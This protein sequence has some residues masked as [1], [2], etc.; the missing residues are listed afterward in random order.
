MKKKEQ[1]WKLYL[2]NSGM[3]RKMFLSKEESL[4]IIVIGM[5]TAMEIDEK[6]RAKTEPSRNL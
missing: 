2:S 4:D 1:I 3:R 6:Y 5:V